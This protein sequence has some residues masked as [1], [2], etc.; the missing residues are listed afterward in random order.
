MDTK[1]V[2]N[3]TGRWE[4]R[5]TERDERAGRSVQRRVSCRTADRRQAE[6]FRKGWLKE[7]LSGAPG[8]GQA[9]D[10]PLVGDLLDAYETAKPSEK[11]SVKPVRA[12]FG[13]FPVSAIGQGLVDR[14]R[15]G[16]R[17]GVSDGTVR[18]EL[19][20]LLAA[21]NRALPRDKVPRISLPPEGVGRE[22]FLR[23]HEESE[24]HARAMGLTVGRARVHPVSLFVA[25]ALDTAARREAIMEL[26][27][28][29][30]DWRAG[31]IDFR[32]PGRRATRKRRVVVPIAV[33]LR[34]LLER[35]WIEAG[36]PTSGGLFAGDVRAGF[37]KFLGA[38]GY[39]WATAHVLRH[40]FATLK[41]RAG[42]DPWKV[43][44]V[45]GDDLKT[46]MKRYGH[47][48]PDHL[49]SA[50]DAV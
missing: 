28:S 23:E 26:D 7:V 46:V 39:P 42:V 40:T 13:G 6:A 3:D 5:W 12:F 21:L 48:C 19:T 10:D 17:A 18:R 27:W 38:S 8:T 34:P 20:C 14:Y 44:G 50:V 24:Y 29:R 35:A 16:A 37:E 15:T 31:T 1:L 22:L 30:V 4:I 25:I 49:R 43:A 2:K 9:G 32:V 41:L 36:S 47:H 11:W 45:L 33:R